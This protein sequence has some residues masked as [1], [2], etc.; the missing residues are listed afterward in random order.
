VG[1]AV[2]NAA[3]GA[4]LDAYLAGMKATQSRYGAYLGG[5]GQTE[6][7]S[8]GITILIALIL[9]T[10]CTGPGCGGKSAGKDD[11]DD[12]GDGEHADPPGDDTG[13]EQPTDGF[14]GGDCPPG[15][16]C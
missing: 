15:V 2:K 16:D 3:E 7:Y 14:T 9:G 4:F 1:R 12:G 8:S 5:G 13:T 10:G 11:E 6:E